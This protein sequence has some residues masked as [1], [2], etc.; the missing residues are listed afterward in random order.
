MTDLQTLTDETFFR[1]AHRVTCISRQWGE[2]DFP[3]DNGITLRNWIL[4][5][6][7]S[8]F[9]ILKG[10]TSP[11]RRDKWMTRSLKTF[12][13][14]N[15]EE[16]TRCVGMAC[17]YAHCRKWHLRFAKRLGFEIE[18]WI[19]SFGSCLDWIYIA[20]DLPPEVATSW[21]EAVTENIDEQEDFEQSSK[22]VIGDYLSQTLLGRSDA[23]NPTPWADWGLWADMTAASQDEDVVRRRYQRICDAL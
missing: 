1:I 10:E 7:E 2:R 3:S 20:H 22:K 17:L 4:N 9:D 5:F 18:P 14:M 19:P 21:F 11:E 13:T 16:F 6:A 23:S 12:L 15:T 8:F